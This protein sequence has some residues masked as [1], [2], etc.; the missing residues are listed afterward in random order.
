MYLHVCGIDVLCEFKLF[1]N[2]SNISFSTAILQ[3]EIAF[4]TLSEF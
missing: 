1:I 3:I 4:D 2:I